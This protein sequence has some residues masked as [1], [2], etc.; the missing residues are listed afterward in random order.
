MQ[1]DVKKGPVRL[2]PVPISHSSD[3]GKI[4]HLFPVDGYVSNIMVIAETQNVLFEL[5]DT[6]INFTLIDGVFN[7]EEGIY[8]EKGS[9][10]IISLADGDMIKSAPLDVAFIFTGVI[11]PDA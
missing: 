10:V 8:V 3:V 4:T 1:E 6:T 11:Q 7:R 9:K 2:A 5:G